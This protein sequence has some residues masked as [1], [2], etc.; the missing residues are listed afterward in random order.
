MNK[1]PGKWFDFAK[2]LGDTNW[3]DELPK[4]YLSKKIDL[5]FHHVSINRSETGTDIY[6]GPVNQE[7]S[8]NALLV[9]LDAQLKLLDFEVELIAPLKSTNN[10]N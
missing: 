8:G 10:F 6:I 1:Y 5:R 7:I 3:I 4:G 9:H 2:E